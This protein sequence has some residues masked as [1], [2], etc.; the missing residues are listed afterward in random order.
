MEE[1]LP[2]NPSPEFEENI[3]SEP[4]KPKSRPEYTVLN[5]VQTVISIALV[6]ATLLTLWNPRRMFSTSNINELVELSATE[7]A[8]K[9]ETK[10]ESK[11]IGLLA[12]HWQDDVPGEVCAD[13]MIESDVNY[14]IASR[15]AQK[16]ENLG[17]T[18]DIFPEYDL[19][20]LNYDGAALI[21]IYSGSCATNPPA[22]SGFKIGGSL[23]A[24]NPDLIDQLA[25][26]L[27]KEYQQAT[28]L[29]FTYEVINTEHASYHI[30]RDISST[31]PA[32]RLELG[33]LNTD[34]RILIDQADSVAEGIVAGLQ[35]FLENNQASEP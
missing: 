25:T 2:E 19:K 34:R 5:G 15:V 9:A 17:Y 4:E 11:P 24:Q 7:S 22:P 31:T 32:V 6:M 14:D 8:M 13:G 3:Q 30:F 33:S 35:C 20:L 12:G 29:P 28:K 21:A 1:P 18:V 16:L 27:S 10:V 23:D 26:C